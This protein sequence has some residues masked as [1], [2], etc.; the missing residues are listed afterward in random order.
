MAFI[1]AGMKQ[2]QRER[3]DPE[4]AGPCAMW[5]GV[6]LIFLPCV[7][8]PDVPFCYA[9]APVPGRVQGFQHLLRT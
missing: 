8:R 3:G 2:S 7:V 4:I 5:P 6:T 1:N 9:Q